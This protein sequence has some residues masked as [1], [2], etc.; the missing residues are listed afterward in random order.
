VN[1]SPTVTAPS[2]TLPVDLQPEP[3]LLRR[4]VSPFEESAV[5]YYPLVDRADLDT[6]GHA[7]WHTLA[8]RLRA[9]GAAEP[10]VAALAARVQ[11]T[12]PSPATL[13]LVAD[14]YGAIRYEALLDTVEL[15]ERASFQAPADVRPLIAWQQQAPAYVLAAVDRA[16]ADVTYSSGRGAVAHTEV[17][18]GPDD[19]IERN[20]GG[21]WRALAESRLQ[22]R[23]EDSWRHNAGLVARV[24]A[25]RAA[26]CGADDVVLAGD[27]R[28]VQLVDA[29]LPA[30]HRWSMHKIAGSRS[31]DGS[32]AHRDAV[33]AT[34]LREA[35]AARTAALLR[36]FEEQMSPVG[37]AVAGREGTVAALAE[38]RVA[39][40]LVSDAQ[41]ADEPAWFGPT[42]TQV[43]LRPE[44]AAGALRAGPL[45]DVAVR[46]ALLSGATV[47]VVPS[48]T[49]GL[50][51]EGIGAIC[52]F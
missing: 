41:A 43:W 48:D 28:T 19:E 37:L 2:S 44:E 8:Q 50:P 29:Q 42:G 5:V 20:A 52:R 22:H 39:V 36:E 3:D 51:A 40:L 45:F 35:S 34:V 24:V 27:V 10:V 38:G 7:R 26:Q 46:S 18:V 33:V 4:L 30:Q 21:G 1:M 23:A 11:T 31:P 32:Q 13:V 25:E 47:R 49:A 6:D 9:A 15:G 16:G 17:V 12:P 14:G